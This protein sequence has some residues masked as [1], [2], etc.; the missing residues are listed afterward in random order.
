MVG[1]FG[2]AFSHPNRGTQCKR[3]KRLRT[4]DSYRGTTR[5]LLPQDP[6]WHGQTTLWYSMITIFFKTMTNQS[7]GHWH[8]TIYHNRTLVA[9]EHP[10][11]VGLDLRGP[12][13]PQGVSKL[14]STLKLWSDIVSRHKLRWTGGNLEATKGRKGRR[15]LMLPHPPYRR[16]LS[17]RPWTI[18]RVALPGSRRYRS[19]ESCKRAY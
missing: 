10:W 6:I 18:T 17:T 16:G 12:T 2:R 14:F 7:T 4:C 1:K 13:E 15:T 9:R 5:L 19:P 3:K 8:H 11:N